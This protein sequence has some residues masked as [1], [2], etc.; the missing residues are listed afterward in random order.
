[1]KHGELQVNVKDGTILANA[2][3]CLK[4][5]TVKAQAAIVNL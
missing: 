4:K 3:E 1:M 2:L 5:C